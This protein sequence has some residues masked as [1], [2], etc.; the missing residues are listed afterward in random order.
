MEYRSIKDLKKLDGNPRTIKDKDFKILCNSIRENRE[1]FEA[2]PLILSNRTG[3]LVIIAGNQRY[4]A[5]KAVGIDS[6]PTFLIEGLSEEKEKEIIIRDNISN[7][8]FDFD[9]LANTWSDLPLADWGLE[10]P[11]GWNSAEDGGQDAEPQIDRAEELNKAW[12]VNTGDLWIIGD[13]K[14]LCGDSTKKEDVDAVMA[15]E[16]AQLVFTD[17]PYRM[18]AEGG[19]NQ[20]IGRAAAKLGEAIKDLT[21]FDPDPFFNI[22]P[23]VFNGQMNAYIFCNKDL[24][25]DYLCFAKDNGYSF[26]ILFWKK[27]SAIPLGG[28]HRPDVE[29]LI[30]IRKN[31]VWNNA[32]P[33]A[34]YSKCLEFGRENETHPTTK[35]LELVA[36]E[37]K[38]S[39]EHNGVVVD[40]YTG[41]GTTMVACQ[42]LNRKCRGIEISPNYCAVILQRMKDAFP[43]IEIKKA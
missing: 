15:G 10:L 42:N 39:S 30:F 18:E 4:E 33:G 35:P 41:S 40:F 21:N 16:K 38:I 7:G 17:P 3:K 32:V 8:E 36:N 29:Y 19:S 1:Y 28:Q 37:I 11:N 43:G 20:P 14:L 27:P 2:R 13:H 34:I 22:L 25:V 12:G 23:Y 6:V 9:I 24:I 26:N 31:A 5:A